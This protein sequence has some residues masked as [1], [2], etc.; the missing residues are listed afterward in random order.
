MVGLEGRM[1]WNAELQ[2]KC[3]LKSD[4]ALWELG[5][6]RRVNEERSTRFFTD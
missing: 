3:Y 2:E 5:M 6:G 4:K 1:F